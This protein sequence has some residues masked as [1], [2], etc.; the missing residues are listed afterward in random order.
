LFSLGFVSSW[1]VPGDA[2]DAASAADLLSPVVALVFVVLVGFAMR[3][4][5][6]VLS[7]A[8]STAPLVIAASVG[9]TRIRIEKTATEPRR[10]V[11]RLGRSRTARPLELML[12]RRFLDARSNVS[13]ER[14]PPRR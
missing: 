3:S 5:A 12:D 2:I 13:L 6:P 4:G 14:G 11:I 10:H 7:A 1:L 9:G 8:G